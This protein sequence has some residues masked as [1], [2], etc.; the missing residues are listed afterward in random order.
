M[1]SFLTKRGAAP[2]A[3]EDL[4][5]S[6]NFVKCGAMHVPIV[7]CNLMFRRAHDVSYF[8]WADLQYFVTKW[9][10]LILA[11]R[12]NMHNFVAFTAV[13]WS[14]GLMVSLFMLLEACWQF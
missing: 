14:G 3:T 5:S 11:A 6:I 9:A 4:I 2:E 8:N 12:V 13:L 1:F 7:Y 10:Q